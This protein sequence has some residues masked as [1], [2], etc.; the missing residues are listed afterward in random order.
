MSLALGFLALFSLKFVDIS[1]GE[2]R[3]EYPLESGW[4]AV[5]LPL[6]EVSTETW[7]QLNQK[8]MSVYELK[9]LTQKLQEKLGMVSHVK[10][11]CGEQDGMTYASFE[12]KISDGTIITLTIQSMRDETADETQ[13]G[14]NTSLSGPIKDVG[15]YIGHL[16]KL[17]AGIGGEPHVRVMLF[18]EY[19]GKLTAS[20]IKE[21]SS[22][23]FRKMQ[24]D[25]INS[26]YV[27]GNSNQKGYTRFIKES[28]TYENKKYNVEICTRYD[29]E[30]NTTQIILATPS[31]NDES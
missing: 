14:I 19:K 5:G 12:N 8:W 7:V 24:A 10:P 30:R 11:T 23:V 18:G 1:T 16:E 15:G 25:Y 2:L 31:F 21:F 26:S 28:T 17:I 27:A 3:Q 4:K 13:L 9:Q 20:V 22:R 29:G 6:R